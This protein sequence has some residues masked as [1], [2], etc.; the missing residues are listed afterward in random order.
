MAGINEYSTT[1]GS[2]T[3]VNSIDIAEGC[4]PS[5]IN[6]A[7]R[8][9]MADIKGV[10]AVQSEASTHTI[11][12]ADMGNLM[13]FTGAATANLTAAATVGDNWWCVVRADGGAVTIDP[14]GSET[15]DG[16]ATLALAD[17]EFAVI[18]CNGTAWFSYGSSSLSIGTDVQAWDQAL[19]DISGL[20]VTDGN[21]IVGDGAN[22]VAESGAT[23][24]TSLGLT[25][26]TDVQ[27]V[28]AEGAFADGDKTKLDGIETAAD[29][30]DETNVTDALD[31]ASLSAATVAT[32]DKVLIQDIDDS[33]VLKTVTAQAIAD[34]STSGGPS[35]G[36]NAIIRTN[37][38]N[39]IEDITLYDHAT[40]FDT[41][42]TDTLNVGTDNDFANEDVVY[43]TTTGTLPTGLAIETKYYVI[44][45]TAT[46]MKLSTTNG[47]SA[48]SITHSSGSG[49][50]T[51]YQAING[52][53]AGPITIESGHT[54]T[55]PYGST[56][57]VT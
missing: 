18:Y 46:T 5:T 33:D 53:S 17:G 26:G 24:R 50:H 45:A 20:A 7:I 1:P 37:A 16:A 2:N 51:I 6:N 28:L 38:T 48:V 43:V 25:I 27:G 4:A 41:S 10:V 32:G 13:R 23:A 39:I 9:I 40:T 21:I 31:G 54:V 44:S 30:T 36:T 55:I 19:D 57:S 34:L 49:T 3:T 15:I 47:G 29:V 12:K 42:A 35:A 14:D 22:W 52:Y 8:Q 56:W 11:V